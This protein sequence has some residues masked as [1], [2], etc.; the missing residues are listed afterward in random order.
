MSACLP[1]AARGL[2]WSAPR[3]ALACRQPGGGGGRGAWPRLWSSVSVRGAP[4]AAGPYPSPARLSEPGW[5]GV[6]VA[7][8][9]GPPATRA[10][11][12]ASCGAARAG[13]GQRSR[14]LGA[15]A[16][17]SGQWSLVSLS[18]GLF[19][20]ARLHAGRRR[21]A[22]TWPRPR[23]LAFAVLLMS[24]CVDGGGGVAQGLGA[25]ACLGGAPL[26]RRSASTHR[27]SMSGVRGPA[28]RA[29]GHRRRVWPSSAPPLAWGLGL[30]H[31]RVPLAVAPVAEGGAQGRR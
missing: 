5:R 1:W 31:W 8:A 17:A 24:C 26:D 30:W 3:H 20:H 29:S 23:L 12:A 6:V 14:V 9:H 16:R 7:F 18:K 28:C 22:S 15:P 19:C 21:C 13:G 11:A 25:W 27:C 10:A 4:R 2:L